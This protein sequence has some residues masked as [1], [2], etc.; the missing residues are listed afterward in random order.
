VAYRLLGSHLL[1]GVVPEYTD[2]FASF[3]RLQ[4]GE[5][6]QDRP[7]QRAGEWG[8]LT[9]HHSTHHGGVD[10][11]PVRQSVREGRSQ[12]KHN[13]FTVHESLSPDTMKT[14]SK[15]QPRH[16]P[17]TQITELPSGGRVWAAM[18]VFS[19]QG[20]CHLQGKRALETLRSK[21]VSARTSEPLHS[22]DSGNSDVATYGID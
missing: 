15:E 10:D 13:Q 9:V 18:L 8:S 11:R 14:Q 21:C 7:L 6:H 3:L 12:N 16:R 4:Q 1:E 22:T 19:V 17:R 2:R 5:L 20:D